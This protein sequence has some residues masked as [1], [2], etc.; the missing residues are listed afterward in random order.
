MAI[1]RRSS[2]EKTP[3]KNK[4]K[5][6][7]ECGTSIELKLRNELE[8]IL[9][10]G[11]QVGEYFTPGCEFNGSAFSV[12]LNILNKRHSVMLISRKVDGEKRIYKVA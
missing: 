6:R 1:K 11:M 2:V 10:A 12:H 4:K 9:V 7:Q 3:H 8:V 5:D